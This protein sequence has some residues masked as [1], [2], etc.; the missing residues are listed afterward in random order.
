MHKH[1]FVNCFCQRGA[2]EPGYLTPDMADFVEK[3]P[4][5]REAPAILSHTAPQDID[6]HARDDYVFRLEFRGQ[7]FREFRGQNSGNRNSGD[8]IFN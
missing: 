3:F 8:S 6:I 5:R 7:E 2:L 1:Y 4:E